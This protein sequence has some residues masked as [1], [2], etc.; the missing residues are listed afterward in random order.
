MITGILESLG[1][2][3]VKEYSKV[4]TL[5][6]KSRMHSAST[7]AMETMLLW[8]CRG[9]LNA[10]E[11]LPVM[12]TIELPVS[13]SSWVDCWRLRASTGSELKLRSRRSLKERF[14]LSLQVKKPAASSEYTCFLTL[15][16]R[17]CW[18]S[19]FSLQPKKKPSRCLIGFLES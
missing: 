7:L 19:I 1:L 2:A 16:I 9:S 6:G 5:G 18:T 11:A 4:D 14:L 8:P 3:V 17:P 13:S 10:T 15:T 12:L